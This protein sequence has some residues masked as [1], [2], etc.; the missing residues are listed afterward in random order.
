MVGWM[1]KGGN[2]L[3]KK[4][5]WIGAAVC[6]MALV[7][8]MI[9]SV[10]AASRVNINRV[11]EK[12]EEDG[13]QYSAAWPKVSGL[14]D[15]DQQAKLNVRFA[16]SACR[17]KVL[18]QTSADQ[19]NRTEAQMDFQVKRN[20]RGMVSILFDE[21]L[22]TGGANG[23]S[24]KTGATFS[25]VD[26]RLFELR[27]L[28]REDADYVSY[29]SSEIKKSI[30]EQGIQDE[31]IETFE[32]IDVDQPFYVTDTQLVIIM[33]EITYF[34]HSFGVLEFPI[35]LSNMKEMLNPEIASCC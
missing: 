5:K 10:S 26:G 3:I 2:Y 14:Q 34:P 18:A 15:T 13:L 4:S 7:V 33:P 31:Q 28:F 25:A 22:Y 11:E 17:L 6:I 30:Q 29:L 8:L 35:E 21:Y 19:G 12:I 32:K 9:P 16:E 20:C 23:S 1:E 24:T 27:D